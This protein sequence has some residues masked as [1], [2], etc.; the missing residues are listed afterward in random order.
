[1]SGK[2]TH[3]RS[4]PRRSA[5]A[6]A[7]VAA[8]AACMLLGCAHRGSPPP[9]APALAPA[10]G[11]IHFV[12]VDA[13]R[14][15][16]AGAG[17]LTLVLA[18]AGAP[19]DNLGGRI[20]A[21][22]NACALFL[23]HGGPS[24]D[25]LDLFVYADDGAALGADEAPRATAS[26]LVCPPHPKHLYAFARVAAGHGM[27]AVSAQMVAPANADRAASAV[28][29]KGLLHE[30]PVAA[31]AWPGLEDALALHLRQVGGTWRDV[32]RVAIPLEPR[33]ATRLTGVIEAGQCLDFFTAPSDDVAYTELVVL[34][35]GGRILGQTPA[36]RQN[37]AMVVCSPA[38]AE[39][40][41]ALR[42]HGG[43]GLAA[44][45]MS[46]ANDVKPAADAV[47]LYEAEANHTVAEALMAL[48][49]RISRKGYGAPRRALDG[50]AN[51]ARRGSIDIDLPV[52]CSRLDV[53]GGAPLRGIEAWLW[54]ADGALLAHDDGPA[55]STSFACGAAQ[56]ARLDVEAVTRSGPF[57]VELR[58]LDA[59][60]PMLAAHPLAAGRLLAKTLA[61]DPAS[62]PADPGAVTSLALSSTSLVTREAVVA[63]GQCLS[64]ALG[65]GPGAEGAELRLVDTDTKEELSFV[66]GTETA[67]T[68][69]CAPKRPIKLRL[70]MRVAA[71]ATDALLALRARAAPRPR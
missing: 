41:F 18:G 38:H 7:S 63:M 30:E 61:T 20:E 46:V 31:G 2:T 42:P 33:I 66:R 37:P 65:L 32:R 5:F 16:A 8:M 56:R 22:E 10:D 69:S 25:D 45:V 58:H 15:S 35:A 6:I 44:V 21:P 71:G 29:A 14:A 39:V 70:E 13:R 23:A 11:T 43:R 60:E 68:E 57:A 51:V 47:F 62:T 52:G 48:E 24:I 3:L 64:V 26:V 36:E 27:L 28:S 9:K 1:M 4:A 34:D 17:P 59:S 54:S 50:T 40:T 12:E 19:G 55:R 53:V 67:F 49:A